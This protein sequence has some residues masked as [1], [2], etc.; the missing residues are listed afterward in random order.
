MKYYDG[1]LALAAFR[2][3]WTYEWGNWEVIRD[4][5][6]RNWVIK[7][8]GIIVADKRGL[9]D[10]SLLAMPRKRRERP[11]IRVINQARA[12]LGG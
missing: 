6:A 5:P 10:T 1:R 3:E 7:Y 9:C 11:A 12:I 2:G 8:R 4:L